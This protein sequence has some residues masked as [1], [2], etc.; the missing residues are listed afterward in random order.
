MQRLRLIVTSGLV[1]TVLAAVTQH[2]TWADPPV[3]PSPI[4][5]QIR[6]ALQGELPAT[7]T[8]DG[9]LEDVLQVIKQ[10]GSVLDGSVLDAEPDQSPAPPAKAFTATLAAEQLLK[11]ARLL[12]KTGPLDQDRAELVKSMRAEAVQLLTE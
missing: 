7:P 4:E 3:V 10:R 8:N 1:L 5:N 12:E 2:V 11:A 6:D 9:V